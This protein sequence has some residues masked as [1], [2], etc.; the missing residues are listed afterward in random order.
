MKYTSAATKVAP[1][2]I[3]A[4]MLAAFQSPALADTSD[5]ISIDNDGMVLTVTA[6][7]R[8][9]DESKT[10]APVSVI[11]Q[12]DISRY[13]ATTVPELLTR[14]PG[15]NITSSGGVGKQTSVFMRGTNS[16]HVL[17]LIDGV[18]Q[19]SATLGTTSFQDL[20]VA[21]IERIEIVRGPR[22]SLYGSEAIGGVIQIFTKKGQKG[23]HP[24]IA[25]SAGSNDTFNGKVSL[26]GGNDYTSYRLGISRE[27]TKGI[28]AC[29][30]TTSG[31]FA[32]E[33]D[34]DG[35]KRNSLS[36]NI[37]HNFSKTIKGELSLLKAEGENEYDGSFSDEAD[38][39]QQAISGKLSA[40]LSDK[41]KLRF[42]VGQSRD[43]SDTSKDG[44]SPGTFQT[45]QHTASLIGDY[46]VN[47]NH[48]LLFGTDWLKTNVKSSTKYDV[49]SRNNNGVFASYTAQLNKT[50]LDA[51]LRYDDNE[52]FGSKTTGGIAVGQQLSN[53][54]R[55]KASYG[56]AFKAPT[57]N[58]LYYPDYGK[59]DL[60]PEES[61]NYEIGLDGSFRNSNW[62]VNLF[63][64]DIDN[65]IG[66]FPVS[67]VDE[68]RIRGAELIFSTK[69]AGLDVA[70]N[71]TF[72]KP[73]NLTGAN[74][75]KLLA[76]RP[77]RILNV[78]IDRKFGRFSVGTTVHAESERFSNPD[79]SQKL[80]GY[81]TLDLRT[82]YA[83]SKNWRLGAKIG[84]ALDKEYTTNAGYNEDGVNGML[85]IKYNPESR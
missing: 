17:V 71:M 43:E 55:L 7:R 31:C 48:N 35:Y 75:G 41:L 68:A 38:F 76:K 9:V 20:P 30:S 81:A 33:P 65:L 51:S 46:A 29:N 40:G 10:L 63:Q 5:N 18:R 36:L 22:S 52:Q 34:L 14:I 27:E 25:I 54:I 58:Q 2:S 42:Q 57:F 73:E 8:P 49:T 37:G 39:L 32:D 28:D 12:E 66:G 47:T 56:T 26:A 11:T 72:Q 16:G 15:L 78:D 23:F 44:A 53:S 77:E 1:L 50:R 84:N 79:N 69:L 85:T 64:N 67:N 80:A 19:G 60:L 21:Q 70:T 24:S 3:L 82:E 6:D 74:K 45:K 59:A 61:Q 13:Q 62:E 4:V 83:I